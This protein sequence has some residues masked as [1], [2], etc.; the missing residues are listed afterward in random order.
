MW[1]GMMAI[2]EACCVGIR[3]LHSWNIWNTFPK[4]PQNKPGVPGV[5]LF[6]AG[7][8]WTVKPQLPEN[9]SSQQWNWCLT[10]CGL[11]FHFL[12]DLYCKAHPIPLL[13]CSVPTVIP[14]PFWG[15]MELPGNSLGFHRGGTD[16]QTDSPKDSSDHSCVHSF[17]QLP[18]FPPFWIRNHLSTRR[19][20]N[21][22]KMWDKAWKH[23]LTEFCE[24]GKFLLIFFFWAQ[25]HRQ[26]GFV[27]FF[28]SLKCFES[29]G[30]SRGIIFF[31]S[32]G[33]T[34]VDFG[35]ISSLVSQAEKL[36][37]LKANHGK[38]PAWGK[39]LFIT[40]V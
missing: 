17:P 19:K 33:A 28:F 40:P 35:F 6:A 30:G 4:E 3:A 39:K 25:L 8:R 14:A 1:L 36:Q 18:S 11:N 31:E 13:H 5:L 37:L 10:C 32:S 16:R 2:P 27:L 12:P 34:F 21:G 20:K 26:E 7:N 9:F 23:N 22:E 29:E 38:V 15:R 24:F